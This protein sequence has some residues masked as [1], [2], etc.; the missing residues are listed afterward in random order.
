MSRFKIS[1][2]LTVL[3]ALIVS[4]CCMDGDG[5][6]SCAYCKKNNCP[7]DPGTPIRGN[8]PSGS[9]LGSTVISGFTKDLEK[10]GA[11]SENAALEEMSAM[12]A[13]E[14]GLSEERSLKIA[15]LSQSW[16]QLSKSR[17]LTNADADAFTRELSGVSIEE[18]K[19]AENSMKQGSFSEMSTVLEKAAAVNNT[20]VENIT[21]IMT[22]LFL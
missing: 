18:M 16:N 5:G 21:A 15:K 6:K 4:A 2:I 19:S 13:S 8:Y 7:T 17:A 14:Y 9:N 11:M 10:V 3:V 20:S 22:K 12:I 1:P